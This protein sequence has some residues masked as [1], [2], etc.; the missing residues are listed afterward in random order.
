MRLSRLLFAVFTFVFI[1]SAAAVSQVNPNEDQGLRPYDSLHGGELDS[2][3]VTT[4]GLSLHIPL[5][6]FPQRGNLDLSFKI[7]FSKLDN[8]FK[9]WEW[10]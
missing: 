5:V 9:A 6:S 8:R 3:S 7:S 10:N 1:V 4:G 2:V